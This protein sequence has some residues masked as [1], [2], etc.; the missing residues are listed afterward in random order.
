MEV[1]KF[2]ELIFLSLFTSGLSIFLAF[3]MQKGFVLRP[4]WNFLVIYF[5]LD[6]RW[7]R[8]SKVRGW[9]FAIA[10][11]CFWCT[12]PYLTAIFAYSLDYTFVQWLFVIGLNHVI[13]RVWLELMPV[14]L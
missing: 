6:R 11:G 5:Y 12:N 4:Y 14:R 10:G 13:M 3:C 7:K 8:L 9:L 2:T 1:L